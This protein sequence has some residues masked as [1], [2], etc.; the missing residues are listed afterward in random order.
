[1][2]QVIPEEDIGAAYAQIRSMLSE[3]LPGLMSLPVKEL[4]G[5][6]YER[7]RRF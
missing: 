6:R 1:V 4:L 5:A 3:E 7:F 2:E